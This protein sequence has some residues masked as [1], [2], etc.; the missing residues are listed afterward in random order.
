MPKVRP[1]F[2][3]KRRRLFLTEWR[4]HRQL[5]QEQLAERTGL[6]QGMISQLETGRSDF[7]GNLLDLLAEALMCEPADLLVR[8]PADSEAPW[9]VWDTLDVPQQRLAVE[10][11]KTLK[12]AS[13]E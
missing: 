3:P 10:M 5:T 13:G 1:N 4:K 11:M 2:K 7:T 12:R 9:S 6:S 8:N